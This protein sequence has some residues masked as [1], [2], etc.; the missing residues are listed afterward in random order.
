MKLNNRKRKR[1]SNGMVRLSNCL[2]RNCNSLSCSN[3]I[4]VS[5]N[6]D[7]NHVGMAEW[8][9]QLFDTQCLSRFVGSIPTPGVINFLSLN[10]RFL[11]V[12]NG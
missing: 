1:D 8:L 3:Y 6:D 7:I 10:N 9:T 4:S 11:E 2:I 5:V 12:R